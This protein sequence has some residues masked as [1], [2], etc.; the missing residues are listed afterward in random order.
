MLNKHFWIEPGFVIA[1]CIEEGG[2]TVQG[3]YGKREYK[4]SALFIV[5]N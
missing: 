1:D 4:Y 5:F 2:K 3:I